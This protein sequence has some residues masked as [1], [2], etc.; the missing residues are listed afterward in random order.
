MLFAIAEN[1]RSRSSGIAHSASR[2]TPLE[3]FRG[4][5]Q[6]GVAY[7]TWR[8]QTGVTGR[9]HSSVGRAERPTSSAS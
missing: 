1:R 5:T 3:N 6:K 9:C 8:I 4:T 7:P 2:V